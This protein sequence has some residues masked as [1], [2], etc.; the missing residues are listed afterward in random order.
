VR[1]DEVRDTGRLLGATLDDVTTTTRD[2]HRAIS[3]RV[4]GPLGRP[5]APVKLIHDGIAETVYSS[6]GPGVRNIPTTV[7]TRT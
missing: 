3:R 6:V 5:G 7:T 1:R 4:F 2:V